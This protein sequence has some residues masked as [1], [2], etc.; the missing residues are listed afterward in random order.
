ML[1]IRFDTVP[2]GIDERMPR[3]HSD[4][5]ALVREAALAKARAVHEQR[6]DALI[7]GCDTLVT[8][9]GYILGKPVDDREAM[10]MLAQLA[11]RENV[12]YS[13][14]ALIAPDGR[15]VAGAEAT[16]VTMTLMSAAEIAGY[17]S[18]GE[19][20]DKAGAYAIQGLGARFIER[21]DGCYFNVVG[22]P[23]HRMLALA[24]ELGI[25]L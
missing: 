4:P 25:E 20:L 15:E 17:V 14:I 11:G 22:L 10:R 5:E 6:T 21:I 18:T 7:I 13:G 23:V 9:D 16:T 12:V 8:L 2:A 3:E 19:P 24:R 1:G